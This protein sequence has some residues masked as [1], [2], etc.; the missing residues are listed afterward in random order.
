MD[1]FRFGR[2]FAVRILLFSWATLVVHANFSVREGRL[3]R[4]GDPFSIRGVV[5]S[6]TPIG[7]T[8]SDDLGQ[9]G[10]SA[11]LY[12]RDFPLIAGLGANTIRLLNRVDPAD[13][14]FRA[15]LEANDLYWLAGF[16]LDGFHDP[17]RSLST[18]TAAGQVL[19]REILEAFRD[20]A[21]GWISKSENRGRLIAFVFGDDVGKSYSRKFAGS[22]ADFH[23]LL[24]EAAAVLV[25]LD[26]ENPPLLTTAVSETTAIGDAALGT[27]DAALP[28]L[29]FWSLNL[30]GDDSLEAVFVELRARTLKPFLISAF[31]VD[32]YDGSAEAADVEAQADSARAR[33]FDIQIRSGGAVFPVLGGIWDGFAD[34]WWRAG[35]PGD[36]D[37]LGRPFEAFPDGRYHAEWMGLFET[38]RA[39]A[40]GLD[41]LKPRPAYFALAEV[42]GG[43]PAGELSLPDPPQIESG[44]VVNLADG[45]PRIAP[46]GLVSLRGS[47]LAGERLS[48]GGGRLPFQMGATSVCLAGRPVPLLQADSGEIRGQAPWETPLGAGET[49]AYRAG[50]PSNIAT[51]EISE[52]APAVFE[53]GVFRPGLPCP[54]NER[55]GVKAGTYLEIYSTGLGPVRS[56]PVNGLAFDGAPPTVEPQLVKLGGRELPL[57][58]AGVLP[59]VV[60]VY[61]TNVFVPDD[62]PPLDTELTLSVAGVESKA[63]PIR[64]I[65]EAAF[66]S[67]GLIG[68]SP[69]TVV[70]QQ[71][72]GPEIAW[73]E[74]EGVNSF[75]DLI[76]FEI[77]GLPAGVAATIPVGFPGQ[78]L[79]LELSAGPE[80]PL[81]SGITAT[82]TAISASAGSRTHAFGLTILPSRVDAAFRVISGGYKSGA[83]VASFE[84]NGNLLYQTHGGGPGR[85][86]NFL[87]VDA[88]TGAL[89]EVRAFDTFDR[90]ADV[91]AMGNYL[92]SLPLGVVVLGSI[93]DE[94][95]HLLTAEARGLLRET[96][97]AELIDF[98]GYQYSWAIITRKQATKPIAE[99][100]SPNG[101]VVLERTLS[102]PM[103]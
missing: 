42:W 20:Y 33:A 55:N 15:G 5:Y 79:P 7:K 43:T 86:F 91:E 22:A 74:I 97:G 102:F 65:E 64:V 17:S 72:A 18:A 47:G 4:G 53:R 31:G 84:L 14:A 45:G 99:G 94:G 25:E 23:S 30:L 52:P 2:V 54:V 58:Y 27:S 77:G 3:L 100:L 29:A 41:H 37:T 67:F 24:G 21:S 95:T 81:L 61:Q 60:G 76:R 96:L 71:G 68:P 101:L 75:C 35:D 62:F 32:A 50:V 10:A 44:G 66:P 92:R 39:A 63:L 49:V 48:S 70:L 88:G 13:D 85:G 46:G 93:A 6:A 8:A 73:V 83:S 51:A 82:L 1:C 80:S 12:G 11:C 103:P 9:A 59:G 40:A 69:A 38:S 89:G 19:R 57:L 87:T 90:P 16:S 28:G 36:H 56:A 26:P 98:V 34:Q 78:V